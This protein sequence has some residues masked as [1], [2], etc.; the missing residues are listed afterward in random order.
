MLADRKGSRSGLAVGD[1]DDRT[2]GFS[3]NQVF[4]GLSKG[5]SRNLGHL[6]HLYLALNWTLP[7][8]TSL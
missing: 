5:Y 3:P 7:N 1:R 6:G 4:T 2:F 8:R